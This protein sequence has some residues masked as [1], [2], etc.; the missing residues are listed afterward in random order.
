MQSFLEW[1]PINDDLDAEFHFWVAE[2]KAA[3]IL[4][5]VFAVAVGLAILALPGRV[6]GGDGFAFLKEYWSYVTEAAFWLGMLTGLLWSAGK[7][8]GAAVGGSQPWRKAA[9]CSE[10]EVCARS[11]GMWGMFAALAG[12]ALWLAHEITVIATGGGPASLVTG[13]L[14]PLWSACFLSAVAFLLI[15]AI[16]RQRRAPAPARRP[17]PLG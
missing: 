13:A 6:G 2:L 15:A 17:P 7:R 5:F 4:G 11:F 9:D 3:L 8:F 12:L 16:G 10:R 1:L 14:L